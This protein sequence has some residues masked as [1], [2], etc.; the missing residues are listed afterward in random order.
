MAESR[1]EK[2]DHR[3]S[4]GVI[5]RV[6]SRALELTL[7][8]SE[9]RGALDAIRQINSDNKQLSVPARF[10]DLALLF[11]REHGS[12]RERHEQAAAKNQGTESGSGAASPSEANSERR[13]RIRG[14]GSASDTNVRIRYNSDGQPFAVRDHLGEWNSTDGGKTWKTGEPNFR[15]RRGEVSI[16]GNGVYTFNND[17]YGVQSKFLADGTSSRQIR[18]P[19]GETY[20]V[21]RNQQGVPIS[22][23]DPGGHWRGDGANWINATTG[24]KRAGSVTL[25]EHGEFRFES[26]TEKIT[27]Q[28]AQLERIKTLENEISQRY[29]IKFGKPGEKIPDGEGAINGVPTEAELRVLDDVLKKTNH[30]N[31]QGMKT[32]FVRPNENKEDYFGYYGNDSDNGRGSHSCSG[33]CAHANGTAR[34]AGGD[35]VVLPKAR[36]EPRGTDGLEGTLLHEFVH[37]EQGQR[38]GNQTEWG[39]RNSTPE[40]REVAAR[41]GWVY[42]PALREHLLLD[43]NGGQWR[44]DENR[45]NWS[46]HRGANT[47]ERLT[48]QQMRERALIKPISDYFPYPY[49]HHAEGLAMFRMGVGEDPRGSDRQKLATTSPELYRIIKQLDQESINR[50]H[51]GDSREIRDLNGHLIPDTEANRRRILAAER[52]W[53]LN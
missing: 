51:N 18:T 4:H 50:K 22:F 38:Y 46:R 9:P 33:G 29:G 48:N 1:A 19:S 45:D 3:E 28:S 2:I 27:A 31:Y 16:D 35:M 21:Q 42:N 36:Q 6:G 34:T 5:D 37:H 20:S 14:T 43:R 39:G 25:T 12:P 41:L 44:Y 24:E 10:G 30:E 47:S 17:D 26:K 11:D 13:T 8:G 49:E 32:W 15:V 40:A 52:A 53:G 7:P 23:S